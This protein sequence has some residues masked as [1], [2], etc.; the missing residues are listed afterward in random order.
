MHFNKLYVNHGQVYFL[1][2]MF[3]LLDDKLLLEKP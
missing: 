1:V 2:D 3:L